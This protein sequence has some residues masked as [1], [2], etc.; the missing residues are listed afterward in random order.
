MATE[1]KGKVIIARLEKKIAV[2]W[3]MQNAATNGKL[4]VE[5]VE[6]ESSAR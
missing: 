3:R 4:R 1:E 6:A 2:V 5:K